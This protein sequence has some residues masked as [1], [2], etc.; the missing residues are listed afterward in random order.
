M[1]FIS[2]FPPPPQRL[3][4]PGSHVGTLGEVL[5]QKTQK[6]QCWLRAQPKQRQESGKT[7]PAPW[8]MERWRG[9]PCPQKLKL[10]GRLPRVLPASK[11]LR[12][13]LT[14]E[15]PAMTA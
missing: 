8:A 14:L 1:S 4:R 9:C 7:P 11:T 10:Q 15:E 12:S 13:N 6:S 2:E 3:R 5:L